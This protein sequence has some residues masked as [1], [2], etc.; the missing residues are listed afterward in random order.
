MRGDFSRRTHDRRKQYSGVLN[1][2]GRLL[3]DADLEEEH[4]ILAGQ[5]EQTAADVIGPSG[6]PLDGAGFE[7]TVDTEGMVRVG[8]GRYYVDGILV[9]NFP[10]NE[11]D[12]SI[13]F[14]C[15]PF[16]P[17]AAGDVNGPLTGVHPVVLDVWRRLV[18]PLDDPSLKE[19]ALGGPETAAREQTVWQVRVLDSI[20][21]WTCVAGAPAMPST[22]GTL[23]AQATPEAAQ[24]TPCLVPARAGYSGLENQF[25]RVEV[26]RSGKS[27]KVDDV[28]LT[29]VTV[30]AGATDQIDVGASEAPEA[31]AFIELVR[32]GAGA[33]DPFDSTF[34][35]VT[36]VKESRVILATPV[37]ALAPGETLAFRP[38]SAIAV[39]SRENGSVVTGITGI[40]GTTVNVTD[41]GPDGV[42][43]FAPRQWVEITDDAVEFDA[44][45][46]RRLYFV[47]AIDADEQTVTL[48]I[49]AKELGDKQGIDARRHPKLRRW[50]GVHGIWQGASPNNWLHLENGIEISFAAGDY[51]R[52][53]HWSFPARTAVM[54]E[55]G[56]GNIEWP[57]VGKK[58]ASLRP[59]G[60][61]RHRAVLGYLTLESGSLTATDCRELFPPLTAMTNLFYVGGDG[62]EARRHD[63]GFPK[64]PTDL[65]VRVASGE[66]PVKDALVRFTT[67][68]GAFTDVPTTAQGIAAF[69]WTLA[70]PSD[71]ASSAPPQPQV[72]TAELLDHAGDPV[73]NQ[74]IRFTATIQDLTTL[75]YVSGDGQEARVGDAAFPQLP[76]PVV[77]R[78]ANG[79]HPVEGATVQFAAEQGAVSATSVVTDA[80]GAA[81]VTWDLERSSA[82]SQALTAT[83]LEADGTP[84]PHQTIT[85]LARVDPA[86]EGRGGCCTTIGD[87][88][89]FPTI[90]EALKELHGRGQRDICLCLL[91]GDHRVG[92][93][94]VEGEF[95]L[96][97][98]GCGRTSRIFVD[99]RFQFAALLSL[100]LAD[101]DLRYS[102]R[103]HPGEREPGV[104][105]V[106]DTA[107][108]RID[109]VHVSGGHVAGP[110]VTIHGGR[111]V[112]VVDSVIEVFRLIPIRPLF[113]RLES[114]VTSDARGWPALGGVVESL[115]RVFDAVGSPEFGGRSGEFM[116]AI[117][118][119]TPAAR[120]RL[121]GAMRVW[122]GEPDADTDVASEVVGIADTLE[123]DPVAI[124]ELPERIRRL[125]S[126]FDTSPDFLSG[127]AVL[128]IAPAAELREL[129]G[130]PA[131][132]T[133]H[134][135][136]LYGDV[137]LYGRPAEDTEIIDEIRTEFIQAISEGGVITGGLGTLRLSGNHLGRMRMSGEILALLRQFSNDQANGKVALYRSLLLS[138][139]VFDGTGMKGP[140]HPAVAA[141]HVALTGNH[142]TMAGLGQEGATPTVLEVVA[143]AAAITGNLA[144]PA[145][146][147]RGSA[148]AII[149]V[150]AARSNDAGNVDLF[151]V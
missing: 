86:S 135:N 95:H 12:T 28:K 79:A 68:S 19:V 60:I 35:Q 7:I 136:L 51:V 42:L 124:R 6:G 67:E 137:S 85:F 144:E 66:T 49:P 27:R 14:E 39:M 90:E 143:L 41:L 106:H 52:D 53:D 17:T 30:V 97:I 115:F 61:L 75:L 45:A 119:A 9:E 113:D 78:V 70:A 23:A 108:V 50:D 29:A 151:I 132:V 25:Y 149:D 114:R 140:L 21:N 84:S 80:A 44:S 88:G 91:P 104:L 58:P 57:Q 82:A 139:N 24:K 46:R 129:D 62:Q 98:R 131:D 56:S 130:P 47:T 20:P 102:P 72:C 32:S 141:R 147:P 5:H 81:S 77:V 36:A 96:S 123:A 134:N 145:D 33:A 8:V 34:T 100:R 128:E 107:D 37:P 64:L 65:E 15:Q 99:V 125:A 87:T 112:E 111:R 146:V 116:R 69:S 93:A 73:E 121:A 92:S 43:G 16:L 83:L 133:I 122:T 59:D 126:R 105:F 71:A 63:I 55:N 18:T 48:A 1:E 103:S 127:V 117:E 138:D 148:D 10:A 22:T 4:R 150:T 38:V 89:E 31:G 109:N 74:L 26:L 11:G 118:G 76:R 120:R 3:T 110:L 54:D 142:F 94:V 2:Q 101:L 40:D 13:P